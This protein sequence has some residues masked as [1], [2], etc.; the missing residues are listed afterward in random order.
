MPS[1]N[2][3]DGI[4]SHSNKHL[5]TDILRHEW[6]FNGVIVSDYFGITEFIPSI[7]S[8]RTKDAAARMAFD[9]GVDVELPF[10][11]AY[12]GLVRA[13]DTTAKS[14]KLPSIAPSRACSAQNSSPAFS[15]ILTSIPTTPKK[16]PTAPSIRNSR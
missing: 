6:G 16:S 14:P 5:L 8:S 9:S 7:T 2:E 1:Y 10:P 15:M 12:P 13:G 11:D 3:I 4:P